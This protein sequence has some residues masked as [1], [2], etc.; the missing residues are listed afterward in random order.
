MKTSVGTKT[1]PLCGSETTHLMHKGRSR[2]FIRC[3][4]CRLIFVPPEYFL[5]ATEE[6]KRYDLHENSPDD[7]DYR[8]FLN[9]LFDPL[10]AKLPAHSCGLDFGSGPGPTLS[11]MFE[12]AGHVMKVYDPFFAPQDAVF[13]IKYD[14]ITATE[15]AEHLNDPRAEL[16]RLWSML[17]PGGLLGIMTKLAGGPE[18]FNRWHYKDEPTHICFYGKET[19]EW[20]ARKW[21]AGLEFFGADV[22]IFSKMR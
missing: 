15:V 4:T 18:E 6:K 8:K 3:G 1:C 22:M 9:R 10:N 7:H 21:G 19:F 2:D 13:D 12:E 20:L 11:V 5:T 16:S 17:K 14:F